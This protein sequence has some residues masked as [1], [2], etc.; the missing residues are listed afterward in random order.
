VTFGAHIPDLAAPRGA[1]ALGYVY[2]FVD[3]GLRVAGQDMAD[4]LIGVPIMYQ[5]LRR[6]FPG[7]EQRYLEFIITSIKGDPNMMAGSMYGGHQYLD[8]VNGKLHGPMGLARCVA[9]V[10]S[11]GV[12]LDQKHELSGEAEPKMTTGA[13]R[14]Q[15]QRPEERE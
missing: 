12:T 9:E 15:I 14:E 2:G 11:N 1:K 13:S 10:E 3:A 4:T 5:V 8:W 7:S 6:A